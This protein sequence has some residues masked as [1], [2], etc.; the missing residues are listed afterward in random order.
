M[1]I[2]YTEIADQQLDDILLYLYNKFGYEKAESFENRLKKIEKLLSEH[3]KTMASFY[4]TGTRKI[5]VNPFITLIYEINEKEKIIY[6]LTFW[7]NRNNPED[8]LKYL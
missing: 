5:L 3:P 1:K 4:D 2:V 7:F 6:F 8:V